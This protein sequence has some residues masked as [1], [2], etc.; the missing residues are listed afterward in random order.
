MNGR[1]SMKQTVF[2]SGVCNW[3]WYPDLGVGE[4]VVV[5]V[6]EAAG[7]AD[8][9]AEDDVAE[10]V[11][12]PPLRVAPGHLLRLVPALLLDRVREAP[13]LR[14]GRRRGC[15]EVVQVSDGGGGGGGAGGGRPGR[16]AEGLRWRVVG[17]APAAHRLP[18][19]H[20]LPI[21]RS[22]CVGAGI[23]GVYFVLLISG[24]LPGGVSP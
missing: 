16:C 24:R 22:P 23:S 12:A 13:G 19:H 9:L 20:Y 5:V 11:A 1:P 2:M 7:A 17:T 10:R 15:E 3:N 21:S 14:R 18:A 6:A 4:D 8:E